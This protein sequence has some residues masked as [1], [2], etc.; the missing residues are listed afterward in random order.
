MEN[1]PEHWDVALLGTGLSESILA[2][3]LAKA[4]KKVLHLDE[5]DY[6]GGDSASSTLL[7]LITW[8]DERS[9]P[10]QAGADQRASKYIAAQRKSFTEIQYSFPSSSDHVTPDPDFMKDSRLYAISLL[11]C[12]VPASGPIITSLIASGTSK[13]GEFCLLSS[14]AICSPRDDNHPE[15]GWEPKRVP[16][17]KEDVFKDRSLSLLDKRK[18]MKFLMFAASDAEDPLELQGQEQ[19]SLLEFLEKKFALPKSLASAI[20]FATAHCSH[21]Q[22]K[23]IPSIHRLQ[24]YL[25]A[26]GRYGNSPFL[27]GHYGGAG[28]IAQGF[29][30]TAAVQGATYILGRKID[31]VTPVLE[32]VSD[33][34]VETESGDAPKGPHFSIRLDGFTN[35]ITADQ[36]VTTD[37]YSGYFDVPSTESSS[38]T[39]YL[40]RGIAV[41]DS[42]IRLPS[43]GPNPTK[44]ETGE[45]GESESGSPNDTPGTC[46][47]VFPPVTLGGEL[48]Q[49]VS[50]LLMGDVSLS[51]PTNRYIV[52]LTTIFK[53][54]NPKT[55]PPNP[56]VLLQPYLDR[57]L[58]FTTAAEAKPLLTCYYNQRLSKA[59]PSALST[60][61]SPALLHLNTAPPLDAPLT[62]AADAAAKEAERVFWEIM[63]LNP[64]D[65]EG[66]PD[67]FWPPVEPDGDDS[68]GRDDEW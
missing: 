54:D 3:A 58:R 48:K 26:N 45:Q 21:I 68:V 39:D 44:G 63:K 16:S 46:L 22:D 2:A 27:I 56:S 51:C 28:E 59:S 41:L 9:K 29:C 13:Y 60:T 38:T 53:S 11:P 5:N 40:V 14:V 35:P 8:A 17:S 36:I 19:S 31:T 32:V 55:S 43:S 61:A 57:L 37:S 12:L 15:D 66:V 47:V 4:G 30:R 34:Q 52:Y 67:S 10:V 65:G 50:A 1:P 20:A 62:E 25:R 64:D 42:P 7:E 6:Y 49:P 18:L 33:S 23:A 24:R